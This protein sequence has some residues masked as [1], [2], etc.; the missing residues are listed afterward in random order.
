MWQASHLLFSKG[1]YMKI[2]IGEAISYFDDQVSNQY[3][4]ADKIKWLNEIEEQIYRD[5]ICT[6]EGADDIEFNGYNADTDI[7]TELIVGSEYAELYRYW[8]EKSVHYA[9]REIGGFNN[10]MAMFQSYYDNY[11]ARYNREHRPVKV[12]DFKVLRGD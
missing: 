6:H 4:E 5:I 1:D 8:L 11:F 2:T 10:A 7:D 3:T 9:N 12:H